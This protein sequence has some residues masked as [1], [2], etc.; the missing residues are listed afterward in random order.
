MRFDPEDVSAIADAVA[1]Q[2]TRTPRAQEF[3]A[4]ANERLGY[5]EAEAAELVGVPAHVLRDARRRGEI[6]ARKIGKCWIYSRDA[7]ISHLG[8]PQI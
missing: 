1:V 5:K 6:S 8:K 7:L 2:L 4:N 3:F